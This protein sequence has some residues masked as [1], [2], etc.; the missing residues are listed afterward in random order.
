[1]GYREMTPDGLCRQ[2]YDNQNGIGFFYPG[3]GA[4]L[5]GIVR[6]YGL[7][8]VDE[9]WLETERGVGRV[10]VQI[11]DTVMKARTYVKDRYFVRTFDTADY[12]N[13]PLTVTARA[14]DKAGAPIGEASQTVIIDNAAADSQRR[15]FAAPGGTP[16]GDG[17]LERPWDAGTALASL[18]S[19]DILFLRGGVYEQELTIGAIGSPGRPTV[20][21]NY[22]GERVEVKGHQVEI[23]DGASHLIVSGI[24]Q[25]GTRW[26]KMGMRI[27]ADIERV[28]IWDCSV[29]DNTHPYAD[30]PHQP[31]TEW[32]TGF[33]A[34][35]IRDWGDQSRIRRYFEVSHCHAEGNDVDGFHL[36]STAHG[37]F[38]FL[39]SC[40]TPDTRGPKYKQDIYQWKHANGF[41]A[42]NSEYRWS[43]YE[44]QEC[45]YLFCLSH[46][47]GQDGWDIRPPH[48]RL[49]GCVSH[50]E[51][52]VGVPFGGSGIKFWEH[53]YHVV[54]STS[55]RNNIVDGT[56]DAFAILLDD[57]EEPGSASYH[58]KNSRIHNCNFYHAAEVAICFRPGTTEVRIEN[59]VVEKALQAI[60]F[61]AAN[62]KGG[63]VRRCI[64]W[65]I[66]EGAVAAKG[67]PLSPETVESHIAEPGFTDPERGNFF[68]KEGSLLLRAGN[69]HGLVFDVDG[70][71]YS[72]LDGL[73]RPRASETEAGAYTRY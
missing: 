39:E 45:T 35:V 19:G 72:R 4:R 28:S 47:N 2:R 49:F 42:D 63:A 67:R 52:F 15:L 56:G 20:V 5:N 25:Y 30:L 8:Y 58:R 21:I 44:S 64:F 27:G 11:G 10:E 13:G 1:M 66:E 68:P 24:D 70:V 32:G 18:G 40:W 61:D 12:P 14:W 22:R 48:T 60:T 17:T 54:N 65:D 3:A 9:G 7:A 59:C 50:D 57:K 73:G 34:G 33:Y 29:R 46:H 38:Q 16:D 55:F 51:S 6:V 62:V 53:D 71:D 36:A 43:G 31:M 41:A 26:E 23:A 69:T 37:R